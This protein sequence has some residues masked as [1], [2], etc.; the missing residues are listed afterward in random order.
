VKKPAG[1]KTRGSAMKLANPTKPMITKRLKKVDPPSLNDGLSAAKLKD[2]WR[3]RRTLGKGSGS[4]PA[5]VWPKEHGRWRSYHRG[6][7][8]FRGKLCDFRGASR[9]LSG[10][11]FRSRETSGFPRT[12]FQMEAGTVIAR[13]SARPP[14]KEKGAPSGGVPANITRPAEPGPTLGT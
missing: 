8:R 7:A 10:S 13:W 12:R 14:R 11:S 1:A 9:K 3:N 4:K 6:P 5:P 2:R